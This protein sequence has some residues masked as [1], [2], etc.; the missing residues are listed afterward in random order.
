MD[1]FDDEALLRD[2]E[3][4]LRRQIVELRRR[5]EEQSE[6]NRQ[7]EL[8]LRGKFDQIKSKFILKALILKKH[9]NDLENTRRDGKKNTEIDLMR[10]EKVIEGEESLRNE[11]I[12]R[13][14]EQLT[15]LQS[16]FQPTP[17]VYRNL[18]QRSRYRQPAFVL[19]E[20]G[21]ESQPC[22][23]LFGTE[24]S[25]VLQSLPSD[26]PK[27][28]SIPLR[29]VDSKAASLW[30]LVDKHIHE[31]RGKLSSDTLSQCAFE[32]EDERHSSSILTSSCIEVEDERRPESVIS[33]NC[34]NGREISSILPNSKE[35]SAESPKQTPEF[36]AT[37]FRL[38]PQISILDLTAQDGNTEEE[39]RMAILNSSLV[40]SHPVLAT[41]Q[42]DLSSPDMSMN[43]M[44][45]DQLMQSEEVQSQ[46][47]Q[48][49]KPR[50][51]SGVK[52]CWCRCFGRH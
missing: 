47:T 33:D 9:L 42:G 16:L 17:L 29:R 27:S 44:A 40:K 35:Y 13:H 4:S 8:H 36:E 6:L 21:S 11:R 7:Q 20:D 24:S 28:S 32:V 46:T 51:V 12:N 31:L 1:E 30:D 5:L 34:T 48:Q 22:A 45:S 49:T 18:L 3:D 25:A 38:S 19:I 14:I 37:T 52:R 26:I 50:P 10:F 41:N 15:R 2:I 39:N 23:P 43:S